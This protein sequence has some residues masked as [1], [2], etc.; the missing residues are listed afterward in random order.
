[1]NEYINKKLL[2]LGGSKPYVKAAKAA[3]ELGMHVIVV[4]QAPPQ[5]ILDFTDE[6][7]RFS[8]LD[9]EGIGNWCEQNP[10]DGILNRS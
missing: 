6:Y 7:V 10:V 8:L 3:K 1:M 9:T 4:D 5:E 2:L